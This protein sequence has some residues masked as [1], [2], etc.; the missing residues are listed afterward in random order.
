[1]ENILKLILAN[2][3]IRIPKSEAWHKDLLRRAKEVEIISEKLYKD[4]FPYLTFRRFFI[5]GYRFMLEK[6]PLDDLAS[7][8]SGV[9]ANFLSAIKIYIEG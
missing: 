2:N 6:V 9:W 4:L 3:G 1:M 7:N 8:I 5:H